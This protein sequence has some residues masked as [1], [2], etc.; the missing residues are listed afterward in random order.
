M[1][2]LRFKNLLPHLTA[3]V[4]FAAVAMIFCKPAMQGM[5]LRQDDNIQW[6]AMYEDQRR[7]KEQT[8][9]QPLWTNR[10]FS[11]MPAYQ[12]SLEAPNPISFQHVYG[13]FTSILPKPVHFFVLACLSFY[14]LALAFRV[15]PYLGIIGG[16]SYA[17]A[18]YHA[19][20][21][22]AGHD[23]KMV[24]LALMPMLV[25]AIHMIFDR[26]Y[27]S[28]TALA[29]VAATLLI[30][31][32]H[33]QISYYT[34]LVIGAMT[35]GELIRSGMARD[36][37]HMATALLLSLSA[38]LLGLACNAV[39]LATTY[40]YSKESIRGGS[41]LADEKSPNDRT[42]LNKDYALSYSLFKTEPLVMMFPRIYGGS[43]GN[44]EVAEDKSKTIEALQQMPPE[45]GQQL[46]SYMQFYW[47]G[48]SQG[49]SGPPY[50]GAIVSFLAILALTALPNRQKYWMTPLV[51]FAFTLSWGHYFEG[52]NVF[53]LKYLP[54]YN[55][56][57]APSMVMVIPTLIFAM[58]A[59]L[60]L[61]ELLFGDTSADASKRFR[62]GLW[63]VA[64]VFVAAGILY[65]TSSFTSETDK[66]LLEQVRQIPDAGQ[67]DVILRHVQDFQQGL[68]E[69]RK[70]LFTGDLMRSLILSGLAGL[71]LWLYMRG[72]LNRSVAMSVIGI[73]IMIDILP[74]DAKYL[75]EDNYVE[76]D[77]LMQV[78][79]PAPHNLEIAKDTGNYRVLD[80][81]RGVSA[82]FN[83]NAFTSVFHHSVG[84]YHAAKLSIYQD[85]IEKQ[86][87]RY[88]NCQPVLDMLNT[89]YIIYNDPATQ[90]TTFQ[91]NPGAAGDCWFV[92]SVRTLKQP[93]L[94]ISALDS[95][96]VAS[97]AV[98]ETEL[99]QAI[100][101]APGDSV[102][103]LKDDHDE[104]RY[105][106]RTAGGGFAVFSEVYYRPGW[107]AYVDGKET[108]IYKTNYVLRGLYLAP[109][110]HDIRFEFKPGSYYDSM[111]VGIAASGMV[112]L[113]LGGA[114]FRSSRRRRMGS[115]AA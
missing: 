38:G 17:F 45:L 79:T 100:T 1:S 22:G 52:F 80:L 69:D 13:L 7:V 104:L 111:K 99:T 21:I 103:L 110:E 32:N 60:A 16:L 113:L 37:R 105:H 24:S 102:W 57:R 76:E 48:I 35:L 101:K 44:L 36:F 106:A 30:G 83:G 107:K 97:E 49:T 63:F 82:A 41:V 115:S 31:A 86:L 28:G 6:R 25:G 5:V 71:C 68:K 29:A 8:G 93:Q 62:K 81:S 87:Y 109:G 73:L 51:L 3:L 34:L 39:T 56:F 84:G 92:N 19:V 12:I 47:G 88:P 108:P 75:N 61:Q 2:T 11:G 14:F 59:V 33:P 50:S 89:K 27:L 20:I 65:L 98:I 112:W 114:A 85:L 72:T 54:F 42:G 4:C 9:K 55:K 26:R 74:I 96:R 78:F 23:T 18:T 46:Q 10:M 91:T 70:S 95:L 94:V 40:E 43:T 77:G 67:R 90:Q 53:M 66:S 15:N 64:G 58:A